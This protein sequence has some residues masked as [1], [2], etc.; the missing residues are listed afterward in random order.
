MSQFLRHYTVEPPFQCAYE[1]LRNAGP[2]YPSQPTLITHAATRI[3]AEPDVA[4][5]ET[6]QRRPC[7]L[8]RFKAPVYSHKRAA[9]GNVPTFHAR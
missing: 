8:H 2:K 7:P 6:C 4:P 3:R 1:I 9:S 5:V